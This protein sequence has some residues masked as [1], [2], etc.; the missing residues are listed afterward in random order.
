MLPADSVLWDNEPSASVNGG[1]RYAA[2]FNP[3]DVEVVQNTFILTVVNG[4]ARDEVTTSLLVKAGDVVD[5][6]TREAEIT[7]G[8]N[9]NLNPINGNRFIR[10]TAAGAPVVFSDDTKMETS[11]VMPASDVTVTANFVPLYVLRVTGVQITSSLPLEYYGKYYNYYAEGDIINIEAFPQPWGI[12]PGWYCTAGTL[13]TPSSMDTEFI[14]PGGIA[15]I[16]VDPSTAPLPMNR[17]QQYTTIVKNGIINTTT[18]GKTI[19]DKNY[20]GYAGTGLNIEACPPAVG[21]LFSGWTVTTGSGGTF[22]AAGSAETVYIMPNSDVTITANYIDKTYSL[23]VNDGTGAPGPH[24]ADAE[25][26]I[27]AAAPPKGMMFSGWTIDSGG[28]LFD[29]PSSPNAIFTIA[30]SNTVITAQYE[31]LDYTLEVVNGVDVLGAGVYHYGEII[32]ISAN[33][34]PVGMKFSGWKIISGNGTFGVASMSDTTFTMSDGDAVITAQYEYIDYTLTV[35]NGVDVLGAGVYHYSET[36]TI[37]ANPPHVGMKF[38]GWEIKSGN[39]SF[40]DPSMFDTTFTMADI[41]AVITAQYEYLDYTLTIENGVDV[42][43][44]G[45]YLY[46]EPV[47]ISANPPSVGMKFNGWE[48]ISGSGSFSDP[49]M[50]DTTFTMADSDAVIT[51]QYEY[52]DYTLTVEN[53]ADVLGMGIYHYG[54][55]V[56]ISANPPPIGMKFSGWE[57]KSG[58]GTFSDPSIPDT[59]FTMSDIDAVITAQYEYLDYTL[60][61]ENGVDVSGKGIY[62]YGENIT[63]SANPP[64]VGMKFS[65]WEIISGS[66]SFSNASESDTVFTMPAENVTLRATYA[67]SPQPPPDLPPDPPSITPDSKVDPKPT[68]D[69]KPGDVSE[70][71]NTEEH[72]GY[73]VGIGN[74]LFAPDKDM[75]RA[76]VAQ[77][78]YNLLVNKDV[79]ITNTFPDISKSAWYKQAVDTLASLGIIMGYPDGCFYPNEPITRAEFVTIAVRFTKETL[80]DRQVY[81]FI[82]VPKTHWAYMNIEIATS[83]GW[84]QGIGNDC[85]EPDR[86]ISRAEVVTLTNRML[87]RVADKAFI[88]N[89]SKLKY[90][91]DVPQTHWAFYNIAEA[92]NTHYYTRREDGGETWTLENFGDDV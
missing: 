35:E 9:P 22:I 25:I 7:P 14:M 19:I 28:G 57:I 33:S 52:L 26:T 77:M 30:D 24:L 80:G 5:I 4:T 62:Q 17:P 59:T 71:L 61:V 67:N 48:I 2:G 34:P 27:T 86:N 55:A 3:L 54:E 53:G 84:I 81:T 89:A 49:S 29:D 41:D 18:A 37:S 21:K 43:G 91:T 47:A 6:F 87:I 12:K 10:W 68:P 13:V 64:S 58:N 11:F 90:Y 36:V 50:P 1:I 88:D 46:G 51:A 83:Y 60:T 92:S 73:V 16:Y 38:S 39:G 32:T 23:M 8:L 70:I 56:P 65:G 45:V 42:L 75:T 20:K 85:F 76:E 31:Y 79:D 78:F 74:D 15:Y 82:D 72:M 66:G 69:P 44:A 40:G 63:I